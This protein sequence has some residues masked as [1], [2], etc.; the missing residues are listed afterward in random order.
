MQF[1]EALKILL[2]QIFNWELIFPNLGEG[3]EGANTK[4]LTSQ[5]AESAK[6]IC[7]PGSPE[8]DTPT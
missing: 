8:V 4:G 1:R 7:S 3:G 5:L 6:E 2:S